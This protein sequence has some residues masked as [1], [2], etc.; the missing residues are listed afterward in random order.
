VWKVSAFI[1]ATEDAALAAQ[2]AIA[3]ALCPDENHPGYCPVPWTTVICQFEDLDP[4]ERADWEADFA[5]DRL[6]ARELG[7]PGA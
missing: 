2:E 4:E 6:R 5:K 1:E 3:R 7:Q